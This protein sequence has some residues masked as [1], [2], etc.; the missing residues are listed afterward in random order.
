MKQFINFFSEARSSQASVQAE[1]RGWTGDGHGNW[2]D[3]EGNLVAKTERGQL[4]LVSQKQSSSKEEE[5][6]S[7]SKK[8][9]EEPKETQS[10]TVD[11]TADGNGPS[12][13]DGSPKEDRGEVTIVFGRF[14]PPTVGHQKLLD[15]AKKVA[16]KGSM[17]IYPSRT[18]DKKKNP[19]DPDSKHDYM[20]R[21]MWNMWSYDKW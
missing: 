13:A 17:R 5:P 1:R 9:E 15:A 19:L 20:R 16:G 14:N 21:N 3:R 7:K 2:F 11:P 18:Q 4:K 6:Q 8:S 10:Q 12:R